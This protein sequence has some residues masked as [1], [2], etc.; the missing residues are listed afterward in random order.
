MKI[1][2][3]DWGIGG[4]ILA[5][6]LYWL[7][8]RIGWS[9]LITPWRQ[10][11]LFWLSLLL[12]LSL[13]S[14]LLRAVRIYDCCHS[15]LQGRFLPTLRLSILH[16]VANNLLPMRAGEAAFPLLMKR[17]FG[18]SMIDSSLSLL[19]LRALDLHLLL[20]MGL[21]ALWLRQREILWL[22]PLLIWLS[23]LWWLYPLRTLGLPWLQQKESR[24]AGTLCHLLLAL[25]ERQPA[26]LR[27]YLWTAL[28]WGSKLMAFGAILLHFLPL[29]W[30]QAL[31]GVMGAELSSVL[32]V[33][34]VAGSGSYEL[35][36]VMVLAPLGINANSV[37][38]GAANLHLFLLGVTLVLGILALGLPRP[39]PD[40]DPRQTSRS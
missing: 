2:W 23:T 32:P 14:Y 11:S 16:N 7:Q 30:W 4:L 33:H 19:W 3:R 29:P 39:G 31:L 36:M 37:V 8:T 6:L 9:A 12:L 28:I 27:L 34:G 38:A 15:V 13:I 10:I 25:P 26:F 24:L 21:I 1:R 22:L 20:A 35:A 18:L 5:T 40:V 17:Y